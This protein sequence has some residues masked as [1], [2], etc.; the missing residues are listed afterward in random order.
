MSSQ[1]RQ[2]GGGLTPGITR[3]PIQHR[4]EVALWGVG[5]MPL[6]GELVSGIKARIDHPTQEGSHLPE[7]LWWYTKHYFDFQI[8]FELY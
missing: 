5:C 6:F 8:V 2:N 1:S 4:G 3:A 7:F